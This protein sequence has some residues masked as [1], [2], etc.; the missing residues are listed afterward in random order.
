MDLND[1]FNVA[2]QRLEGLKRKLYQNPELFCW[3]FEIIEDYLNQG[4]IKQ[5]EGNKPVLNNAIY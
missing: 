1:N 5:M 2:K 3:Y 4:I